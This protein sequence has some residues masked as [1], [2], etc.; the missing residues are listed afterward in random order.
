MFTE[1]HYPAT[2]HMLI[3]QAFIAMH[4]PHLVDW[5]KGPPGLREYFQGVSTGERS[6]ALKTASIA[7]QHEPLFKPRG[8]NPQSGLTHQS[9]S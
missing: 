2:S 6:E 1:V 7:L 8:A 5:S 3:F 9:H 4:L